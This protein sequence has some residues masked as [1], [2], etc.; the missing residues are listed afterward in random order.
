M[1][2]RA[3]RPAIP[4]AAVALIAG[5]AGAGFAA[6]SHASAGAAAAA[7]GVPVF[8][9]PTVSDPLV[10]GFEPDVVADGSNNK[11]THGNVYTS[12]PNG[13]STTISY[14]NVSADKGG[15]FHRVAGTAAG[16]PT[17]CVGGGDSELQVGKGDGS[18]LL[19]DLQGLTN[20]STSAS[21]DGGKT[22]NTTCNGVK[23][24]G[25]DRQWIGVDD[26][27]GK[28]SFGLNGDA[29]S[30]LFY[31]NVAQNT[32]MANTGGNQPVVNVSSDGVNYGGCLGVVGLG[33]AGCQLPATV[34]SNQDDIVG[35]AFVDDNPASSRFHTVY[36]IR[37]NNDSSQVLLT[38]CRDLNKTTTAAENA[39][40][41]ADKTAGLTTDG[42]ASTHWKDHVVATLP[43][44]FVAKV[45]D[46]ADVDSAGNL[47]ATWAQY[48]VDPNT[49]AYLSTGQIEYAHS[50]DGGNHWSK[51]LQIN[52]PGQPTVIFPWIA[53]GDP[54]R[55]AIAYYAAPQATSLDP[56][57]KKP[58]MGPDQLNNGTW[59]VAL[60]Q[61]T[62]GLSTTPTFTH[63]LV[64]D[65]HN[66]F[67]NIS[68]GGLGGSKD[69]SLGDYLQVKKGNQGELLVSYVDDTSGN[70]SVDFTGGSGQTPAEA[71]GPAM[72]A[73]Q[74]GGPSLFAAVGSLGSGR[75]AY[76]TATD[77]VGK[78]FP[79]AYLGLAG[80]VTNATPNLDIAK[81]SM[82]QPDTTHL[83]I[84]MSVADQNLAKDL[85]ADPS[86]G[87]IYKKYL[88]RWASR[89]GKNLPDGKQFY[90]GM[91]AD[92]GGAT[93][94]YEGDTTSVDTS[95][96]KYYAFPATNAV[97]GKITP[98]RGKNKGSTITW[99][100]PLS[101][102]DNPK[103]GDGL[104]SVTGYTLTAQLPSTVPT[105]TKTPSGGTV[106]DESSP[107]TNEIDSAPSFSFR[108][109]QNV[110]QPS[111]GPVRTDGGGGAPSAGAPGNGGSGN[112]APG[113]GGS[114]TGNG[115]GTSNNAA[116]SSGALA[117][118][119]L[120][121]V[122]PI[123]ALVLL[124]GAFALR[125]RRRT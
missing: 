61:T 113:N 122:A 94:F 42:N 99:T 27:G 5:T 50:I 30:Y 92:P 2:R 65:H 88:V 32:S 83:Q 73:H 76:G 120:D 116:V 74:I 16:K 66:K 89:Y 20:F 77:P 96:T 117:A 86:L 45:F 37:G 24:T 26:N 62:D 69:R 102:L 111:M 112:G 124:A 17:T 119:G 115:S 8:A 93:T 23:G 25:V 29:R 46:V 91:Q 82:T 56:M 35:N 3:I 107:T 12:W 85:A 84:Q 13:F 72:V 11:D 118:T 110:G 33:P 22:F 49:G 47:Y 71:S 9:S 44:G 18:L 28:A 53:A 19:A 59:D 38:S 57:T 36:E 63:T 104:F 98:A 54:G 79:D 39:T 64:T 48:K 109:G 80:N 15:T 4:L 100:V 81:V 43:K 67:G 41:C 121:V 58:V 34:I 31:D 60:A 106:G 97:P 55:V 14:L 1:A 125:R 6:P 87:G 114:G 123:T 10:P 105:V 51:P 101:L 75:P 78:G 103:P 21:S 7:G 90:V 52:T 68:T 40:Y 108:V 95:R 70:R